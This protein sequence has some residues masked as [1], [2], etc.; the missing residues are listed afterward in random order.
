MKK[1]ILTVD[2]PALGLA[3]GDEVTGP[4]VDVL[5]ANGKAAEVEEEIKP[6]AKKAPKEGAGK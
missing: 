5:L 1:Y 2:F 4:A 6:A 3:A